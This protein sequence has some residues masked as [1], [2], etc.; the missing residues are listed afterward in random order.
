MRN[1]FLLMLLVLFVGFS[2]NNI[3]SAQQKYLKKGYNK[4]D[5]CTVSGKGSSGSNNMYVGIKGGLN[6]ASM[7]YSD[8]NSVYSTSSKLLPISGVFFEYDFPYNIAVA[9]AIEF[10]IDG[11]DVSGSY[12]I[13]TAYTG[14]GNDVIMRNLDYTIKS[15]SVVLDIP[16]MYDIPYSFYNIS[17]YIFIAPN[18]SY[19]L[20]DSI[21]LDD[22]VTNVTTDTLISMK[23]YATAI[24]NSNYTS[25][26]YGVRLGAGIKYS[27]NIGSLRLLARLDAGY[28]IGLSNTYSKNELNHKTTALNLN[29]WDVKGTR[30]MRGIEVLLSVGVGL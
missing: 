8:L 18:F 3:I 21:T 22:R 4:T 17:S 27:F 24:G 9:P 13:S 14:Y 5:W 1:K 23:H 7:V 28:N 19:R 6:V 20:G 30:K 12:D 10:K 26:N 11:T 16:I 15:K 2:D 29:N 25:I